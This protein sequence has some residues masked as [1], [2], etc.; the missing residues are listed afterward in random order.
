M[1]NLNCLKLAHINLGVA[2]A[3]NL[4]LDA[5]L[6]GSDFVLCTLNEPYFNR[7]NI[8]THFS[9]KY[10]LY[11]VKDRPRAAILLLKTN[12]SVFTIHLS[13]TLVVLHLKSDEVE[14]IVTSIYCPPSGALEDDLRE[15][16]II[17]RAHEEKLHYILGDFNAKSS[18]WGQRPIDDRGLVLL[19]FVDRNDLTILNDPESIPTFS[20]SRGDSWIDLVMTNDSNRFNY[21]FEVSDAISNSD[22]NL[23]V[24]K[25]YMDMVSNEIE[26]VRISRLN[27][28]RLK[29]DI[30]YIINNMKL[31]HINRDNIESIIDDTQKQVF[32]ICRS[33]PKTGTKRNGAYWWNPALR[34]HRSRVRA[35]R[36]RF[37][38]E[39]VEDVRT[40]LKVRYK[41]ELALYKRKIIAA[42]RN[43]VKDYLGKVVNNNSFGTHYQLL[44][45]KVNSRSGYVSMNRG[46][47]SQTTDRNDTLKVILEHHFPLRDGNMDTNFEDLDILDSNITP[48]E[49]QDAID[50]TPTRK[51]PGPDGL[52][53]EVIRELFYADRQWFCDI[54]NCCYEH[55]IFPIVWK[56]AKVVLIHKKDKDRSLPGSYRPICLLPVWGKIYDKILKNR[57]VYYMETKGLLS[58]KQ[59]G[60]RQKLSTEDALSSLIEVVNRGID[61]KLVTMILSLDFKNAFNSVDCFR[62]IEKLKSLPI[63]NRLKRV[64]INFN[65]DR[66][67]SLE[68]MDLEYN[69]GIPQGSSLGPLLWNLYLNDIFDLNLG[70]AKIQAFADDLILILQATAP[71]KF[72]RAVIDPLLKISEW[73]STNSL[74]L[75]FMKCQYTMLCKGRKLSHR[76]TIKI[77]AHP[78]KYTKLLL[79]LGVNIDP[80]LT[81]VPHLSVVKEK[82]SD[83]SH[84]LY[85]ITRATW[86]LKAGVL[87][88]IYLGAVEKFISYGAN[89][90]YT[91]TVRVKT[92]V[93]QIQR[94]ALIPIVKTYKSVSTEAIQVLAG[95][96]PL[97]LVLEQNRNLFELYKLKRTICIGDRYLNWD[98]IE[99]ETK[100]FDPPWVDRCIRWNFA[101]AIDGE[102]TSIFTDGS[103]LD[104]KVG[105]A[106][107][108]VSSSEVRDLKFRLDDDN[109][110]FQAEL[111]AIWKAVQTSE[112]LGLDLVDI[113]SDSRSS[114]QALAQQGNKNSMVRSILDVINNSLCTFRFFWIKAHAGHEYNELADAG[115]KAATKLQAVDFTAGHSKTHI[116]SLIRA[117]ATTR[118]QERWNTCRNGRRTF[119]LI[120]TVST[121]RCVGDFYVNQVLTGHGVFAEY[122]S[123]F[124]NK[125]NICVCQAAIGSVEHVIYHCNEFVSIRNDYF[126]P[127]YLLF[128]V[129]ELCK[130]PKARIGICNILH[131]L[132]TGLL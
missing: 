49:I 111:F 101:E 17:V 32:E 64:V 59:F 52:P 25:V 51:A 37:Q 6:A 120:N 21:E 87:K 114:L 70:E 119:E 74:T 24:L 115:A 45:G 94:L 14:F 83:F 19:E 5:D 60:F 12:F 100:V 91:G 50:Q 36:R 103:K 53:I 30:K 18:T 40:N 61:S 93:L 109:S 116:K 95:V 66:V 126:P 34:C 22:H 58:N 67:V 33:K 88:E 125:S 29:I 54:L 71:Y 65:L 35:L 98:T 75:N 106:I 128:N 104:G 78:I 47:G 118:W 72:T 62:L 4:Q 20:C 15:L 105:C 63:P 124:H 131:V 46:D 92:K 77:G 31:L 122:Q 99:Q 23:V 27:W 1:A 28:F 26:R 68:D 108:I 84:R 10:I 89:I 121:R 79:Y 117:E 9:N 13:Q 86:G 44:R 8:I 82:V 11:Y 113:Y 107:V 39:A 42:K 102:R 76:P 132:L 96:V 130:Q 48:K 129:Y 112:D 127:N 57:L 7:D 38:R 55:G 73:I 110:V 56:R 16:E 2:R 3:A 123:R 69:T 80:N 41:Q 85:R 90:W 43:A 81:W 97:D